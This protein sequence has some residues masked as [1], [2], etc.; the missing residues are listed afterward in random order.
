MLKYYLE[1]IEIDLTIYKGS[2]ATKLT[3]EILSMTHFGSAKKLNKKQ[4]EARAKQVAKALKKNAVLAEVGVF[5]AEK[6][7]KLYK[8]IKAERINVYD[9]YWHMN[10][11]KDHSIQSSKQLV[12]LLNAMRVMAFDKKDM[13]RILYLKS[14]RLK[15]QVKR[16]TMKVSTV[17]VKEFKEDSD[18]EDDPEDDKNSGGEE[19]DVDVEVSSY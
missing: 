6:C 13:K 10:L 14:N 1:R 18:S 12:A 16:E 15:V 19:I 3:K 5:S 7:G 11:N 4:T 2:I 8:A 9:T 17:E